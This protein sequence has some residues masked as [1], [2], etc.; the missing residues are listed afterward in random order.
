M[1]PSLR[2]AGAPAAASLA[3][4]TIAFPT[5]G[6]I[7]RA[8]SQS[9]ESVRPQRAAGSDGA[10]SLGAARAANDGRGCVEER[11]SR[12]Q[13]LANPK[14]IEGVRDLVHQCREFLI[15]LWLSPGRHTLALLFVGMVLV[16]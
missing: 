9:R 5:G 3:R 1:P 8:M 15:T 14:P 13:I 12:K 6:F 7:D 4:A 11:E 10:R 16:I 2:D